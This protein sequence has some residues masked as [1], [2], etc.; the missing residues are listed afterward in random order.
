MK[1]PL[2]KIVLNM[3]QV[4]NAFLCLCGIGLFIS[5]LVAVAIVILM[6]LPMNPNP[7]LQVD[8]SPV[9]QD[10][11]GEMLYAFLNSDEQWCFPRELE[12]M[13]PWLIKATIAVEDQRFYLHP[14][15][16]PIAIARATWQNLRN[17]RTVSGAS[18]L[19]MQVIKQH[20]GP[21]RGIWQKIKQMTQAIRLDAH[22]DKNDLLKTYLNTAPYG[23]NLLGVDSAA[24][25]YFSKP[26]NELTLAEA[27]LLAGLP[28]SPTSYDPLRFSKAAH[29]RRNIVLGRMLEE[30]YI[31]RE[32]HDRAIRQDAQASWHEFPQEVPHFALQHQESIKHSATLHTTID[33]V[34]Q[35][36]AQHALRR[37]LN[38]FPLEVTNGAVMVVHL[39]DNEVYARV[40]SV[41]FFNAPGGGQVDLCTAPRSPGSTLKPFT[42]ALAMQEQKLYPTEM[43]L[44]DTLDFGSYNPGNFDGEFN[45]LVSA[46]EALRFSLNVPAVMAL[47]RVEV[48]TFYD[49]LDTLQF[50]TLEKASEHYGLGITLGNCEVKLEELVAAYAMLANDGQ[51]RP[52]RTFKTAQ[53]QPSIQLLSP[54]IAQATCD[55][56]RQP[57]PQDLV[58]GLVHV[59]DDSRPV[60]WKTGT[61]TGFHD[62]WALAFDET[63]L[64]AVWMGNNDGRASRQLVGAWA[65]LPLAAELIR[66]MPGD[67]NRTPQTNN[68]NHKVQVCADSGLPISPACPR[69]YERSLPKDL[70]LHRRCSVHSLTFDGSTTAYWPS[71]PH[72]WNLASIPRPQSTIQ[73]EQNTTEH[74]AYR[75]KFQI[76]SPTNQ[77]KFVL[78][79]EQG[80]DQIELTTSIDSKELAAH[81]STLH[82]YLNG[83]YLGTAS[84]AKPL[85]WKM[86]PGKHAL[87]CMTDAGVMDRVTITVEEPEKGFELKL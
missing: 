67:S 55:M 64:V 81:G 84:P 7:Y 31:T 76:K 6:T 83:S 33:T 62:A 74:S 82:W 80:A 24:L 59:Q 45:G 35:T 3:K 22:V 86:S 48:K 12:S 42:Y 63:W 61:S 57:M 18:T 15:V 66:N 75:I 9:L 17:Q 13:N 78:T 27:A 60:C 30:G 14:G 69:S 51:F 44:D 46:T 43:L 58:T 73:I 41:D 47:Q 38:R 4:R 39:P 49:F 87:A 71:T 25:R 20:N 32:M 72:S 36:K 16:D 19:T 28:Q 5:V 34:M 53:F 85:L 50:S 8:T 56:L 11:N 26:A 21:A 40:G 52:L 2:P 1:M 68:Y 79:H 54:G 23:R 77:A 70:Y 65:A 29:T 10:R 37:H